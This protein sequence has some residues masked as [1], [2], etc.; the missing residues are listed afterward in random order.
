MVKLIVTDMDGTFLRD[1]GDFNRELFKEVRDLMYERDVHFAPCTGK[2]CER[3]EEL[4]G[5][6]AQD[7]WILGD[8]ATRIMHGGEVVYASYLDRE[9]GLELIAQIEAMQGDLVII[10]STPHGAIVKSDVREEQLAVVRS[11]FAALSLV[12]DFTE[13]VTDFMKITVYDA[14]LNSRETKNRLRTYA[15][16]VYMVASE[17]A[18]LDIADNHVDKGTSVARLQ[19]MLGVGPA[20]TMVFGDGLNDVELMK[21]G[22]Y[23]FAMR[24]GCEETIAAA[25]YITGSNEED[26]VMMTILHMLSIA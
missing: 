9:I 20:D 23:S 13:V 14:G 24:N 5:D 4:F 15:D 16:D 19:V 26:A 10:V 8:S 11:S 25:N 21:T 1:N 6:D 22:I 12:D 2:Q 3:V 18:W 7:M 17:P